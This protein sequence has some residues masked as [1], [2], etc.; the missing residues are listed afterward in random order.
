MN[1]QALIASYTGEGVSILVIIMTILQVAPIE[2]NPWSWFMR[3]L[4]QAIN[5]EVIEKVDQLGKDLDKFE[6]TYEEREATQARIRILRFNDEIIHSPDIRHT[7]EHFDQILM[8]IKNYEEY[9]AEHEF[10]VNH[11]AD[12][13]IAR[14]RRI[15]Q[16]CGDNNSFLK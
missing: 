4:G 15:Y 14:I 12:D 13:A 7:K 6:K 1:L 10:Y 9:C 16:K 11:I 3:K 8:D 2:I 5:G